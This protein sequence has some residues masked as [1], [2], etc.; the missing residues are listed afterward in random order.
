MTLKACIRCMPFRSCIVSQKG[1]GLAVP[2]FC[3]PKKN[4][5]M[6]VPLWIPTPDWDPKLDISPKRLSDIM[7][8][9]GGSDDL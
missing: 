7:R 8:G 5:S 2:I 4:G 1:D 9:L 3:T 6:R